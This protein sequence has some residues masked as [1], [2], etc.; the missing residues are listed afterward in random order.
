MLSLWVYVNGY[1]SHVRQL[2]QVSRVY[3]L[4]AFA[5]SATSSRLHGNI[6]WCM[7]RKI[8]VIFP[9]FL[10]FECLASIRRHDFAVC[11]AYDR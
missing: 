1:L 10:M 9:F 5:T 3:I 7:A 11:E 2:F 6:P 4:A 8:R